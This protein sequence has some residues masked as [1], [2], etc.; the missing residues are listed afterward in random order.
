MK[1]TSSQSQPDKTGIKTELSILQ[2][3]RKM[4]ILFVVLITIAAIPF[5]RSPSSSE[6]AQHETI[7]LI[8]QI[9]ILIC[10]LGRAWCSLY[11]GGRKTSELVTDGPYS[12]SRNPL[13]MFSFIGTAG[14]GAQTGS[15]VV[16]IMFGLLAFL[17]FFPVIKREEAALSTVFG[18]AFDLYRT[19]TP[20]FGPRLSAWKDRVFV[21]AKL[22]LLYRTLADGLVFLIVIPL[23]ELIDVAQ[24]AGYLKTV[25]NL[26]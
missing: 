25:L 23:F 20:R 21:E 5:V 8:G 7:E 14:I 11:I 6:G 19:A 2:R 10:I 15:I 3:Q 4:T 16:S 12:V 18:Q 17:I 1:E 22:P 13:Y 26:I 24:E 9:L